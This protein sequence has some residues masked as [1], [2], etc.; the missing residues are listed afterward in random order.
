VFDRLYTSRP[1]PGRKVGT[2]LGLAI[3]RELSAAMGGRVWA[4]PSD[5]G[6]RFVVQ[7]PLPMS[8][9]PAPISSPS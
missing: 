5:H 4:E 3:V 7:L 2:G 1:E 6:A 9:V 8:V